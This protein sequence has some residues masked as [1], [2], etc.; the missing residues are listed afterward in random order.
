MPFFAHSAPSRSDWEPLSHH[1]S[2][3]AH[4]AEEF[5][6]PF[7]AGSEARLAG[8]LHDLGKYSERFVRR[9]KG[10]ESGLDHWSIGALASAVVAKANAQAV[11]FAI[12]GHHVGLASP[13]IFQTL[14][15]KP[16]PASWTE[17]DPRK[18][19]GLLA[20]DG[21]MLP[22]VRASIYD[23]QGPSAAAMV[24]VRMLFSTLVD[25][26]FL[27]TEE[28]FQRFEPRSI[29]RPNGPALDPGRALSLVL[30]AIEKKAA[31]SDAAPAVRALRN[32]LLEAC[33]A[34]GDQPRERFTLTA[35]TGSGKTLAMLAFAL[36]HAQKHDLRRIVFAVP[37]VAILE[38]TAAIYRDLFAPA[39]GEDYVLEHHSLAGLAPDP[40][41][42]EEPSDSERR[43]RLLAENWDA[44]IILTTNVQLLESLFANRPSACRKLHRLADSVVLFDEAQTIPPG[45][46]IPTLAALS[47][48][49]ERYGSTVVFATATQPAFDHLDS[50]VRPFAAAGWAP[51]EVVSKD[52]GLFERA[53]RTRPVWDLDR[54]KSF[55]EIAA[56]IVESDQGLAIVN[57]KRHAR[58]LAAA[59]EALS[60]EGLFH[61]STN[62]C[63]AHREKVLGQV[64]ERLETGAPCRLIATQC[65]EAGVDVDF[66]RV[67]RAFG[68]LESI[69]Q[70]AGRCNRNGRGTEPGEVRIFVPEEEGFPPGAYS[71]AAMAT[72]TLIERLGADAID[73]DD[74]ALYLRYYR[75]FFD[76]SRIAEG[77]AD[78]LDAI[79]GHDFAEV[80]RL[81]RL[82]EK[83]AIEVLVP[84][85]P[86][87]FEALRA[88]VIAAGRPLSRWVKKARRH[89]VSLYRPKRGDEVWSVLAP[90]SA[91]PNKK[92]ERDERLEKDE[93]F[94]LTG[95]GEYDRELL[96]L[97]GAPKVWI[98]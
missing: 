58:D 16:A 79:R 30:S 5:A 35:P 54:K 74:P 83:D 31:A 59:V 53:R 63:P 73:L 86:E 72:R 80:A 65:V 64:R 1:L 2:E 33:L 14:Q 52:L 68:P 66:P 15:A 18:A 8:L 75:D 90:L 40:T 89:A 50:Q 92:G 6:A 47:R 96:G 95:A 36:R 82:I 98:A 67:W 23:R 94:V 49:A 4:R 34:A 21:L 93:W 43:R 78:L 11:A 27:A 45:L 44:P 56:E 77:N 32:D 97:V 29:P 9:L 37:Y 87:A 62:L 26:D 22:E 20:A 76:G 81:Y 46:A 71:Q 55:A 12:H 3:V 69:A 51:R 25:A 91:V 85:D 38:Q 41:A 57:L 60:S 39:F 19:L 84:Y 17:T 70:A 42:K 61:L 48:L 7:G 88:E 28:H 10:T 13:E 24:D